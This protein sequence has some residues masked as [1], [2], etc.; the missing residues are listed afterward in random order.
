MC[1]SSLRLCG[2][3]RLGA[4][5]GGMGQ[6][7]EPK[8]SL[9]DAMKRCDFEEVFPISPTQR[10]VTAEKTDNS[11]PPPTRTLLLRFLLL[12]SPN[13]I[14]ALSRSRTHL[15]KEKVRV[16]YTQFGMCT[17][18]APSV[19]TTRQVLTFRRVFLTAKP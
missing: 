2:P 9:D 7:A 6:L 14:D 5:D 1:P 19:E 4:F 11:F 18:Y 16:Y 8:M 10:V 17:F 12:L 13:R 15:G 3:L